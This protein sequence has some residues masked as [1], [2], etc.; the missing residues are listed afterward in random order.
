MQANF[1]TEEYI[2]SLS[3]EEI[4]KHAFVLIDMMSMGNEIPY[5]RSGFAS[6]LESLV[7]IIAK[8]KIYFA[9]FNYC[10]SGIKPDT[11]KVL[12]PE[13]KS[14]FKTYIKYEK[15]IFSNKAFEADLQSKNI[16]TLIIAGA[17][18]GDCIAIAAT[19]SLIKGYKVFLSSENVTNTTRKSTWDLYLHEEDDYCNPH[20]SEDEQ[21]N[22]DLRKFNRLREQLAKYEKTKNLFI[23]EKNKYPYPQAGI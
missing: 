8:K 21:N 6:G 12:I 15:D 11:L 19:Q 17:F 1:E 14:H 10:F 13:D 2:K 23:P 22:N 18:T 7:K 9:N 3:P 20:L 4:K 16:N 5:G